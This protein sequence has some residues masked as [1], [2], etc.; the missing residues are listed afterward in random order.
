V[1]LSVL[2]A[3][4]THMEKSRVTHPFMQLNVI[5][6]PQLHLC[7]GISFKEQHFILIPAAAAVNSS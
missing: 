7:V 3:L 1:Y 4:R 5:Q 2:Y 6:H